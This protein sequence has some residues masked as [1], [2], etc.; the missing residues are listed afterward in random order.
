[1]PMGH[2]LTYVYF[3]GREGTANSDQ[4]AKARRIAQNVAKL[5]ELL[6]VSRNLVIPP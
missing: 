2:T 1:M 5:R 6:G 3:D 4:A